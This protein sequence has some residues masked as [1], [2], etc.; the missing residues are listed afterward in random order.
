MILIRYKY[1]VHALPTQL[2]SVAYIARSTIVAYMIG[3]FQLAPSPGNKVGY[4]TTKCRSHSTAYW[5]SDE[6]FT[7]TNPA[8][9]LNNTAAIT[10]TT[11]WR[12]FIFTATTVTA[13]ATSAGI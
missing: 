6:F 12:A 9:N 13:W 8:L 3:N 2:H 7:S 1:I 5:T 11:F 10:T 4:K